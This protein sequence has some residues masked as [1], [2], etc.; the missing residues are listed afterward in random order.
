MSEQDY[1]WWVDIS[2]GYDLDKFRDE[3][4]SK[5]IWGPSKEIIVWGFGH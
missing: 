4:A 5:V 2:S 3:M 1:D